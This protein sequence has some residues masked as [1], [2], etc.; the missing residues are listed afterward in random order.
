VLVGARLNDEGD[1]DAG[2]ANIVY[3]GDLFDGVY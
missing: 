2:A 1:Y 3:G